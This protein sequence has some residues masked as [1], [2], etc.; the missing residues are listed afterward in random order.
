MRIG[1]VQI[2]NALLGGDVVVVPPGVHTVEVLMTVDTL[3][4]TPVDYAGAARVRI[5]AQGG[6]MSGFR[7]FIDRATLD[8]GVVRLRL[9]S[10]VVDLAEQEIGGL[11]AQR[12]SRLE[13]LWSMVR[14]GGVEQE[15]INVEGFRKGPPEDFVVAVPIDGLTVSEEDLSLQVG[16]VYF[17]REAQVRDLARSFPY[18]VLVS[19]YRAAQLWAFT[20][21][22]AGTVF[23]AEQ[24][25]LDLIDT[26]IRWL[27]L[28]LHYSYSSAPD[29]RPVAFDRSRLRAHPKRRDVVVVRGY[30]TGRKWIRGLRDLISRPD[31]AFDVDAQAHL[32]TLPSELPLT[33]RTAN[34]LWYQ[35]IGSEDPV[36]QLTLLNDALEFYA[37]GSDRAKLF[38]PSERRHVRDAVAGALSAHEEQ[39]IEHGIATAKENMSQEQRNRIDDVV[40]RVIQQLNEPSFTVR[41]AS[42]VRRDGVPVTD[43]E[44]DTIKALRDGRNRLTHGGKL[45]VP[46]PETIRGGLSLV[47][48]ML[49]YHAAWLS[50]AEH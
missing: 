18:E 35:A 29:Q 31:A 16:D 32:P 36:T 40:S 17:T 43:A 19:Q 1:S 7:G 37:S 9:V 42:A 13:L 27:T 10:A 8:G 28:R 5:D 24:V 49:I 2:T 15:Q 4:E 44:W 3:R 38:T 22:S 23:D 39:I 41:L 26:A 21:V 47:N 14:A 46:S 25:G 33:I 30:R 45:S 11:Q 34:A 20:E 12:M 6:P 48:R 50:A